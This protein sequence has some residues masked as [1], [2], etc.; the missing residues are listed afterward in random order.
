MLKAKKWLRWLGMVLFWFAAWNIVSCLISKPLL[1]PNPY[2]TGKALFSLIQSEEFW[3]SAG[4]T[5]L[6]ILSG[7]L[8]ALIFGTL[9][10]TVCALFHF[11]NRLLSPIKSIVKTTPVSSFI[12]LVLLWLP[13]DIAPGFIAFLMAVPIFWINIM[14]G[15]IKTDHQLIEMAYI[16]RFGVMKKLRYITIPSILPYFSTAFTAA[17]GFAWKAGIAAEVI[18]K[19]RFSIGSNLQNA[20]VYLETDK[21]FAWTLIVVFLSYILEKVLMKS[22]R[23][24]FSGK[25]D[26]KS[27]M[28]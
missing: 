25:G 5:I 24:M 19:P 4:A 6:R 17:F 27:G 15:I 12:I 3:L 9:L 10:G 7:F 2:E 18:A 21:L 20:K 11:A 22:V 26:N 14:E 28:D 23:L 1:M 8:L 13:T 16:Y